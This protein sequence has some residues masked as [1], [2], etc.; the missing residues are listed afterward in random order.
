[1]AD[2]SKEDVIEFLSD[3]S[4]IELSELV[5][6]LEEEWDVSAQATVAAGAVA[7]GGGGGGEG[8]EEEE[9]TAFDVSLEAFGDSKI[10]V[11]KAVREATGLGLKDAKEQV[12]GAPTV[13]KEGLSKED[14]E[15]LKEDLEEAGAEVELK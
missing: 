7:G 4:V 1:M 6:E 9:Q 13:I 15:D 2:V 10:Q 14:A 11:I 3:M 8:E 12:E 5:E